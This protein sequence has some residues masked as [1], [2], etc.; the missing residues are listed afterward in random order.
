MSDEESSD[1]DYDYHATGN[2]LHGEEVEARFPIHDCCEFEDVEAL[3]V[4]SCIAVRAANAA[5]DHGASV[6]SSNVN[7]P[8]PHNFRL[9]F[10]SC[11]SYKNKDLLY[12]QIEDGESS[13]DD[14][15]VPNVTEH[16]EGA[17]RF[18]PEEI[19]L[20][21]PN[22]Q[23]ND[24]NDNQSTSDDND[25]TEAAHAAAIGHSPQPV[26][27]ALTADSSQYEF[28][29]MTLI[30]KKAETVASS[31]LD[32]LT[33][34]P[35]SEANQTDGKT[36][37]KMDDEVLPKLPLQPI[38]EID[39]DKIPDHGLSAGEARVELKSSSNDEKPLY[40]GP[41]EH[42]T[43]NEQTSPELH[44][45]KKDMKKIRKLE[46]DRTLNLNER[47]D[48]E[49]SPLHI[50]IIALKLD[51]VKVLL[52]AGAS[53]RIRCDGSLPVHTAI[54]VGAIPANRQFAYEC[55]V[56]LHEHG[57]D[58][59]VKDDAVHTPLYLACMYNLPQIV[60]YILSDE[61][62]LSTL[63]VRADRAGNRPL[64]AAAKFDTL[65]NPSFGKAAASIAT[66]QV[67]PI[68]LSN[69][70][71]SRIGGE[72]AV[73]RHSITGLSG[74]HGPSNLIQP[75]NMESD[76]VVSSTDAL[77][78]QVLLGT[79]G[80]EVDALNVLGQTPLHIACTKRNWPVARLLLQAGAN[81]KIEDRRGQTP[82]HLCYKR[83]MPIPN[84]LYDLLGDP[85]ETGVIPPTREFIV[86]PDAS[87]L[88]IHH[89]LCMQHH[90][91]P[92]ILRGLDEPPPENIRRLHVLVNPHTGILRSG[93]FGSVVWNYEAR[94]ASMA[95]ILKVSCKSH[96]QYRL[97]FRLLHSLLLTLHC[98][99]MIIH[100]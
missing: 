96:L 93:E 35:S 3:K 22:L 42:Q 67:Q 46:L 4:R 58:L 13:D 28:D 54:S 10:T 34:G 44:S 1:E 24:D 40:P 47:D 91:C 63:N 81:P 84:D 16:K 2:D 21:E 23:N 7:I 64:H 100:M 77:L 12:I 9:L 29:D 99:S 94:R 39:P 51:H 69:H 41:K 74:K 88:L 98:R 33:N 32:P 31:G 57:A 62:G 86:D 95:D 73:I 19:S 55:L 49:N 90:T 53:H 89:E 45:E 68:L 8:I 85:P 60:T 17:K 20:S 18:K 66:G 70:E 26:K 30:S 92:P 43:E 75:G 48:D 36:N 15:A 37:I 52:E 6:C 5:V 25:S 61:E 14:E 65:D 79:A 87:T 50:A 82:G 71:H 76:K 78:T 27:P 59:T 97:M 11:L 72:A 56:V 80:I 38:L 83:A